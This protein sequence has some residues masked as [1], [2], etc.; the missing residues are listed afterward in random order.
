MTACLIDGCERPSL[1]RGVCKPH[2]YRLRRSGNL[3][4]LPYRIRPM[5][6]GTITPD[7]YLKR[8][9]DGRLIAEHIRVAEKALGRELPVGVEIHHAN[10]DKLNNLPINLVICP[11]TKY[12]RLLHRRIRAL[13]ACGHADWL[14]CWICKSWSPPAS[15]DRHGR[16]PEC[17]R[18]Y[19][20]EKRK[21]KNG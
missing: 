11:D 7:G 12:H 20:R 5:G 1:W 14:K 4:D 3:G 21:A 16:H 10:E 9:I 18:R 8:M 13:N 2:Y 15:V 17:E 6:T 19:H